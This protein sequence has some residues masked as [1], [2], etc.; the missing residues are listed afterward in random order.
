MSKHGAKTS[1]KT[2]FSVHLMRFVSLFLFLDH[3]FRFPLQA[4]AKQ[5]TFP[6]EYLAITFRKKGE[7]DQLAVTY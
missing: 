4:P 5:A 6:D 3:S 2:D 7:S 1:C